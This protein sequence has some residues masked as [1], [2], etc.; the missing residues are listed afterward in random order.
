MGRAKPGFADNIAAPHGQFRA[1]RR[2]DAAQPNNNT[3]DKKGGQQ[4][5]NSPPDL[6][7]SL[8]TLI[9]PSVKSTGIPALLLPQ[10]RVLPRAASSKTNRPSDCH[11]PPI[12]LPSP[13]KGSGGMRKPHFHY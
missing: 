7:D 2:S 6:E 13:S 4:A 8:P 11:R 3:T 12:G 1:C 5:G 10:Q 9:T